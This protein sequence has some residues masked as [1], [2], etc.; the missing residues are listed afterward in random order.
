MC[1]GTRII[2]NPSS[3][4]AGLS[5]R[6]RG[7]RDAILWYAIED[8]SIPACAGEPQDGQ[9]STYSHPV[10]PRVCGGTPLRVLQGRNVRG[11][12]P[13]VR[14]NRTIVSP[15][16]ERLRSIPAC[17][18]EP[19]ESERRMPMCRVYP[20]VCGGTRMSSKGLTH[21]RGLSPRVRGNHG[22]TIPS[23]G[24]TGSIPACAGE[25]CYCCL[26]RRLAQVYPR[27]CGGTRKLC[28]AAVKPHGLSPRVRGNRVID[29][30][31]ALHSRSIPACA[32]EPRRAGHATPRPTVYPRVCGGTVG[33]RIHPSIR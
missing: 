12:S 19:W 23:L 30:S 25:P 22:G 9:S 20:R 32:G 11:L 15:R 28:A 26:S 8:R 2:T 7:N 6:V 31:H 18:G 10:Y 5:P 21:S 24:S 33:V 4:G 1:G 3:Y 17:A 16:A 27:V 13:R 14:G 29:G